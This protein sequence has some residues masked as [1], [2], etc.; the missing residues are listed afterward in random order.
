MQ[1]HARLGHPS[2]GEGKAPPGLLHRTVWSQSEDR[3]TVFESVVI[4]TRMESVVNSR[5][6]H[7]AVPYSTLL[8]PVIA[9]GFNS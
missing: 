4:S 2:L 3:M 5:T 8:G 6:T 9:A 7:H 1:L